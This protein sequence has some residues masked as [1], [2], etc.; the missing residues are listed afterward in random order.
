MTALER[1]FD[2]RPLVRAGLLIDLL[3]GQ[4]TPEDG[5][6]RAV[7]LRGA[8]I[9]GELDLEAVELVCPLSLADCHFER[10]VNL[11]RALE[12]A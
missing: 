7:K 12:G 5:R 9:T 4:R 10:P 11:R 2:A 3:T 1:E 8:R 6:L